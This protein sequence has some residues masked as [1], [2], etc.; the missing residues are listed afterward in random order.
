MALLTAGQQ[1][2]A[3][4]SDK[5]VSCWTL[6][7]FYVVHQSPSLSCFATSVMPHSEPV[8]FDR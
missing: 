4:A 3:V 1:L 7:M 5:Q 2:S 6:V 8:S